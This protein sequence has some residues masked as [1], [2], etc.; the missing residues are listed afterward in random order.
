M[1]F[2]FVTFFASFVIPAKPV[3]VCIFYRIFLQFFLSLMWAVFFF[4]PVR[5][6]VC[7][8]TI[9]LKNSKFFWPK[10]QK[11]FLLRIASTFI[12]D[13]KNLWIF[14]KKKFSNS[15]KNCSR[16]ESYQKIKNYSFFFT[17][18]YTLGSWKSFSL[19]SGIKKHPC[20][21]FNI[22]FFFF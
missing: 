4:I 2:I 11:F 18:K 3:P 14:V 5:A 1:S 20:Y 22:F 13:K 7:T 6:K 21:C 10:I 19:L 9:F 17:D 8:W 15:A 12:M 16:T